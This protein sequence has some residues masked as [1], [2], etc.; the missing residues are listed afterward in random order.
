MPV[1]SA[2]PLPMTD[3]QRAALER[4][5]RSTSLPHRKVVQAKALL[6]AADGVA[7]N[8]VARRCHTTDDSVRAWRRR[9]AAQGVEGV[10]RIAP[11]R[12]RKP[13]LAPG[14]VEAV[15]RDTLHARPDDGSTHWSTRLMAARHGIGKDAVARIW[16]D[17]N[18]K[19]WRVEVFKVSNDPRFEDKLVDVV[20]LYMNP[21]ERAAVFC[22]DERPRSR[23]STA[24]SPACRCDRAGPGR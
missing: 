12:G 3:E 13:W 9:F 18:L 10:G 4:M 6:L 8:E 20:G 23:R 16:R 19:P 24:P 22:F 17:H 5:A 14:T 1:M 21:P 15:V 11:G 7:T 2:L